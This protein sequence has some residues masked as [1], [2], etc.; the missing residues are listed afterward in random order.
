MLLL[1]YR[2]HGDLRQRLSW[3]GDIRSPACASVR[4]E[5]PTAGYLG[6]SLESTGSALGER[7]SFNSTNRTCVGV[8]PVFS[9]LWV[10]ASS[11]RTSP[12]SRLTSPLSPFSATRRRSNEESV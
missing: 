5:T 9:P 2:P 8:C 7:S 11:H 6:P 10:W 12:A 3:P 4:E 1:R